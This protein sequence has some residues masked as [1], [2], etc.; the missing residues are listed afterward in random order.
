MVRGGFGDVA[1]N[2]FAS[3]GFFS[4]APTYIWPSE[5]FQPLADLTPLK[6]NIDKI[7]YGL[8]EWQ[9]KVTAKG[10]Y[11]AEKINVEGKDYEEAV[12]NMNELFLKRLWSDGH[13]L[14]PP[15]EE[16]VGWMLTGTDLARDTLIGSGKVDPAGGLATVESIAVNA[17]M[18]GCRPE[19]MPVLIAAV[20]AITEPKFKLSALQATTGPHTP[21]LIIN[22]PIR[23]Q[24]DINCSS[25]LFGPGWKANTAIGCALRLIMLNIGGAFPGIASMHTMAHPGH[26][27]MCI[28]ENEEVLEGTGWNPHHVEMGFKRDTSTVTVVSVCGLMEDGYS[29]LLGMAEMVKGSY[30]AKN[31]GLGPEVVATIECLFSPEDFRNNVLPGYECNYPYLKVKAPP[32]PTK[33]DAVNWLWENSKISW[34]RYIA[35]DVHGV[36][37]KN[38]E[39]EGQ[40]FAFRQEW[41]GKMIPQAPSPDHIFAFVAGGIGL[42]SLVVH[43]STY[44]MIIKEIKLPKN[45]DKLLEEAKAHVREPFTQLM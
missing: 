4:E 43:T 39:P 33:K 6:E 2:A 3:L 35:K 1:N 31:P 26:Y 27:G 21:L 8:T 9:P 5:L 16:Q 15:T 37:N 19:Y 40:S 20:E 32:C 22:G 7:V 36:R 42:H 14:L 44:P 25:G 29:G 45:W 23:K 17:V 41:E 18:A 28:G 34:E 38:Y 12:A 11:P 13:N 30:N 10:I 24:L